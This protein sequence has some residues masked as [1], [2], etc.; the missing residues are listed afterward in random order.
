MIK[1]IKNILLRNS[2]F[3]SLQKIECEKFMLNG[4]CLEIGN[5]EYNDK[6]FFKDFKIH[7]NHNLYFGDIFK[8]KK[9]NYFRLNLEKKNILRKKFDTIIIFN[10]LELVYD[11]NNALKEIKKI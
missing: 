7:K 2:T 6:S 4:N 5:T 10:V 9:K 11:I 1:I 8:L 3:R